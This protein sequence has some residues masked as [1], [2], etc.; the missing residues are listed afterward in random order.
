L[1]FPRGFQFLPLAFK[2]SSR[3]VKTAMKQTRAALL[4]HLPYTPPNADWKPQVCGC[5]AEIILKALQE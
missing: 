1:G 5:A 4:P 2:E 3:A